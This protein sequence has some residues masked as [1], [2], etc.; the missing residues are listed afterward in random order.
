MQKQGIALEVKV[1]ALILF[2]LG[3][4]AAFIFVLGDFS[5]GTRFEFYVEFENAGGLKPGADVAIAGINVGNV[6]ELEF[7]ENPKK[8][9][10]NAV[11]VR[12][13]VT[14][15]PAYAD[16]VRED[17][18]FFITTR[19]VL[20]EPYI[21]IVTESYDAAPVAAGAVLRGVDPPRLDLVVAK[22]TRLLD[23]LLGVLES[24]SVSTKDFLIETTKLVETLNVILTDNRDDI[25]ATIS[26]ARGSVDEAR[27]LLAAL[28][29]GVDDGREVRALVQNLSRAAARIEDIT[30]RVD[31]KLD[32]IVAD[33]EAS[34]K[35]TRELT[36]EGKA[37]L[38][39]NSPA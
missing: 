32:P 16:A 25:D 28:H 17:S 22:V 36:A 8:T 9:R 31:G 26:G 12:T 10:R 1:G 29:V 13:T 4:L 2:S 34:A 11:A 14:I 23:A 18:E 7:V 27:E 19:G 5:V 33:V 6:R 20:G 30:A 38:A 15:E 37:L 21:E 3:L 39:K 24:P 35:Q